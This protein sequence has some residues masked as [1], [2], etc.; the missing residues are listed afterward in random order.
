MWTQGR[1][2]FYSVNPMDRLGWPQPFSRRK[3]P[4][5]HS[6]S[7]GRAGFFKPEHTVIMTGSG[8][9]LDRFQFHSV[10]E[11][12]ASSL[13]CCGR[14][15]DG[16]WRSM[17]SLYRGSCAE[18]RIGISNR[19][20][21]VLPRLSR[22]DQPV[23]FGPGDAGWHLRGRPPRI[24]N[25]WNASPYVSLVSSNVRSKPWTGI[26]WKETGNRSKVR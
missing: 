6:R 16:S 26:V 17:D 19:S 10:T 4:A 18:R 5:E 24:S 12:A 23:P 13:D 8:L 22:L 3:Y 11:R 9:A 7:L 1:T 20:A 15:H 2:S 14:R 25:L 21:A